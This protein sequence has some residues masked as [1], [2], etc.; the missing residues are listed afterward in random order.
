M[1]KVIKKRGQIWVETSIYTLIAFA[2]IGMVLAFAK[3]KIE[4]I[5]SKAIIDQ[6]IKVMENIDVIVN[7]IVQGGTGNKRIMEVQIK[8][9]DLKID[10]LND[11]LLFE[12]KGR[13]TYSE[14]GVEVPD[15]N[16]KIYTEKKGKLNFVN[17]TRDYSLYNITYSGQDLSRSI[18]KASRAYELILSNEG[19]DANNKTII[20]IEVN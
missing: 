10:G 9:G 8:A 17:V 4:Q 5:Q 16:L 3:P 20:N 18:T 11:R 1:K 14:P 15:G 19:K 2:M 12:T 7:E 6:S 13:Y